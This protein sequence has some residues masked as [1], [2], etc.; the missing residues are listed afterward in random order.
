M[1]YCQYCGF[2]ITENAVFCE[3][4]GK[5]L[6]EDDYDIVNRRPTK[7]E[8][9]CKTCG[10]I[11]QKGLR[12][13]PDCGANSR[14]IIPAKLIKCKHCYCDMAKGVFICPN[15]GKPTKQFYSNIIAILISIL[16]I[17]LVNSIPDIET[18]KIS[19]IDTN[20]EIN[21]NAGE[22]IET[23]PKNNILYSDDFFT[24][25]YIK[26]HDASVINTCY[27]QLKVTNNST[28]KVTLLLDDVYVNDISVES[29]T[30]MPIMLESH[31]ISQ[32]PFI[33]FTGNTGLSAEEITKIEFQMNGYNE[34]MDVIHTTPKIIIEK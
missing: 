33:L 34:S 17:L 8:K 11:F 18:N 22:N 31:K 24:I 27:L 13:C 29:G 23:E 26:L 6:N 21:I 5:N 30:A 14:Q 28:Q 15:C 2:K 16:F 25:E 4:C 19:P 12:K 20:N 7:F 3:K 32:T 9:R 10:S 1:K